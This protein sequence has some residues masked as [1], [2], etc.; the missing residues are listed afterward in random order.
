V[1]HREPPDHLGVG[2]ADAGEE[3]VVG[4]ELLEGDLLPGLLPDEF[5]AKLEQFPVPRDQDP[6]G[7]DEQAGDDEGPAG[8][9][10]EKRCSGLVAHWPFIGPDPANRAIAGK[11]FRPDPEAAV[12]SRPGP[13]R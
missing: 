2:L 10:P 13:R 9:E 6:G 7:Q 11:P 3:L 8:V 5:T 4:P 1:G 12:P